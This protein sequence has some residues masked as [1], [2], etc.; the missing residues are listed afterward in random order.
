MASIDKVISSKDA[1]SI[2]K[3][4]GNFQGMMTTACRNLERLL[5]KTAGKFDQQRIQRIQV[6]EQEVKLRKL[7]ESFDVLHQAYQEF[8]EPGKDATEEEELV[9]K[10]DQHYFEVA[11]KIYKSLQLVAEY[12]ESYKIYQAGQP[13]PELAK[14]E[15]EE[16]SSKEALAKKLKE[17]E[18]FY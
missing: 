6:L 1:E 11:D 10:Q 18:T 13:D 4:R 15:A 7:Q 2:K 14:K 3:R 12:E 16:K 17:E 8:R 5:V 9:E